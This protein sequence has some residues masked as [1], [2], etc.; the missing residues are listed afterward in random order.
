M[1]FRQS[2]LMFREWL[3]WSVGFIAP[4]RLDRSGPVALWGAD[5]IRFDEYY[6][7]GRLL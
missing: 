2:A 1:G 7:V 5:C 3:V 6:G 4:Q